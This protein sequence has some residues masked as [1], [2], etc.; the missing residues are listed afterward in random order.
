M[1]E[2]PTMH[3]RPSVKEA[4]EEQSVAV[5]YQDTEVAETYVQKRFA[6][7]W[8]RLLHDMQ[9]REINRVIQQ[10]QPELV[11]EV[12]P[13]PARLTTE[14]RGVRRGILVEY[15]QEMLAQAQKRLQACG[16]ADCWEIRHGNAFHLEEQRLQCDFLY[17]FRFIRHF[18]AEDRAR[19]Y[20]SLRMCLRPH[21]LLMFDVV[22]KTVRERLD[23]KQDSRPNGQLNVYDVTYLPEEFC[24]EI[25]QH[26]FLLRSLCP[27]LRHFGLQ[28]WISY[29]LDHR[30]GIWADRLVRLLE[31]LPSSQPLEW[32][33]LCQK[34]E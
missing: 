1:E 20:R 29:R 15:S 33:A 28:S 24:R 23:A 14:V 16:L 3:V 25:Q 10:H 31:R 18:F 6:V 9:V 22:N 34:V 19:L 32:I 4:C 12:A 17:T 30:L 13:G 21:G 7:S 2:V 8:S 27:V 26:G 11:V 5:L